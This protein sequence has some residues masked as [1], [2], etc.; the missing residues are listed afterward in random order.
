MR[1]RVYRGAPR[2]APTPPRYRTKPLELTFEK[3]AD[4]HY[5]IGYWD[6]VRNRYGWAVRDATDDRLLHQA[7]TRS[8]ARQWCIDRGAS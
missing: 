8:E 3:V 6:V 4:G 2:L 5:R 1:G 7:V